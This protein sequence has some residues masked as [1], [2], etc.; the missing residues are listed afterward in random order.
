MGFEVKNYDLGE[1]IE[2]KERGNIIPSLFWA[3]P[4][5]K[6]QDGDLNNLW[7]SFTNA[8]K[9]TLCKSVGILLVKNIRERRSADPNKKELDLT[10]ITA[11]LKELFP[12]KH[13]FYEEFEHKGILILSGNYPQPGWG[14]VI[15]LTEINNTE[16]L[17]RVEAVLKTNKTEPIVLRSKEASTAYSNYKSISQNKPLKPASPHGQNHTLA[18]VVHI[19]S[20]L[21]YKNCYQNLK[22]FNNLQG[23]F[24]IEFTPL[25]IQRL[26]EFIAMCIIKTES[27]SEEYF[28]RFTSLLSDLSKDNQE[29]ILKLL[30]VEFK[31]LYAALK[32]FDIATYKEFLKQQKCW[33]DRVNQEYIIYFN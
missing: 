1:I 6:W 33:F 14:V 23:N 31:K 5:G 24:D 16:F 19:T 10:P 25:S 4:I 32:Y 17:L 7:Y 20:L 21:K 2:L 22:A 15:N 13:K 9:E 12:K 3:I 11:S 28:S 18:G 30:P 27:N 26:N 8:N 29:N